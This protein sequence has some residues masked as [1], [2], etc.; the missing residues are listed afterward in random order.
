VVSLLNNSQITLIKGFKTTIVNGS[1]QTTT[2]GPNGMIVLPNRNELWAGDGDG[3]IKVIDLFSHS[4]IANI[5]TGST[6]RVDEFAYDPS[7]EVVVVTSP[8]EDTPYVSIIGAANR[9]VVGKIEFPGASEL[10]QPAFNSADGSFYVSVPSTDDQPGGMI[11]AL[12]LTTMS[13]AQNYSLPDCVPAGI[14]FGPSQHLFV[15][16]SQD[17]IL[18]FNHAS[19]YVLNFANT[20]TSSR[21]TIIANIT[22][23]AGIDQ[24]AYD[25]NA[26]LFYASAYQMQSNGSRD[27][28]PSPILGIVNASTNALVQTITTDN[29][30]AHS[31]A[32]DITTGNVA[33]PIKSKGIQVF[34]LGSGTVSNGTSTPSATGTPTV[35]TNRAS[36]GLGSVS[37][38]AI[39]FGG[40]ALFLV[41]V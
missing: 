25:A 32:F 41:F 6:K 34:K 5:T 13:I 3:T 20:S 16:C 4:L 27:G 31:V 28:A 17:Q 7:N 2:S 9:S 36:H 24:V 33:V 22:G 23:L 19:S 39:S 18:D 12:D 40:V 37:R 15:G 30:T 21:G 29:V 35:S 14:V 26:N 1:I 10:E 38:L 8:A 11:S